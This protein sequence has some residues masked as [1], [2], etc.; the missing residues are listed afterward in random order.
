[1][2]SLGSIPSEPPGDLIIFSS[3]GDNLDFSTDQLLAVPGTDSCRVPH[4]SP[5]P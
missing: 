1:M 2:R 5:A 3:E 4:L